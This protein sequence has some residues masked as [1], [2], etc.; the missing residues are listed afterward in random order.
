MVDKPKIGLDRSITGR[1][2]GTTNK[3][4]KELKE[5]VLGALDDAGGQSYLARQAIENPGPFMALVGKCLPK[6]IDLNANVNG[7]LTVIINKPE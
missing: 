5:M 1:A 6:A 4:T 2:K 3:I 7:N